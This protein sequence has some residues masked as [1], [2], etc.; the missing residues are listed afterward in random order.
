MVLRHPNVK[1]DS[2]AI[3]E[4]ATEDAW[5]RKSDKNQKSCIDTNG[6]RILPR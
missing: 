2:E 6:E 5:K 3:E 4:T 1:S